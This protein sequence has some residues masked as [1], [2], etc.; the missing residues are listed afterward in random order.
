MISFPPSSSVLPT[1]FF[2]YLFFLHAGSLVHLNSKNRS[3]QSPKGDVRR[4]SQDVPVK[5]GRSRNED[6]SDSSCSL[7]PN[8]EPLRGVGPY[9]PVFPLGFKA[10]ALFLRINVGV[11]GGTFK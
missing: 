3:Q 1:F 7:Y 8:T 5:S 4:N 9:L 6:K 11:H 2:I 10:V